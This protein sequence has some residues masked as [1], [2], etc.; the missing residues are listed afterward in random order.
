MR[1]V[2]DY[3]AREWKNMESDLSEFNYYLMMMEIYG[4][5]EGSEYEFLKT[6]R[7]TFSTVIDLVKD[8]KG[9]IQNEYQ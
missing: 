2:T 6:V 7:S 4:I 3:T 9:A 8:L 5:P 1:N